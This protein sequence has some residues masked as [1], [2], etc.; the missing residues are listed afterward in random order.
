M[1][2]QK[3]NEEKLMILKMVDEGKIST[4]EAVKLINALSEKKPDRSIELED[5][6][7][8]ATKA[9]DN[10]AKDVKTKVGE[11]AKNAEPKVRDATFA[12]VDKTTE[13]TEELGK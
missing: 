6:V 5:K 1:E 3:M 4:N 13:I 10:F 9:V 2:V 7:Q 11:I 12:I 8:K